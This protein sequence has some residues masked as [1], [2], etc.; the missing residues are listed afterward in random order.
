MAYGITK[1]KE[2]SVFA[3]NLIWFRAKNNISQSSFAES[4]GL[5]RG[6]YSAY[7]ESRAEP[8]LETLFQIAEKLDVTIDDL[9]KTDLSESSPKRKTEFELV[10]EG[11]VE[12]RLF[13]T[14]E[15][16]LLLEKLS[17]QFLG[18]KKY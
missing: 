9:L 15:E 4:V 18:V 1:E 3:Y 10:N 16:A 14:P 2:R 6:A 13:V 5:S 7:E 12:V 8:R 11:L 17:H